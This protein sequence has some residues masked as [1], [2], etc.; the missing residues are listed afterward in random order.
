MYTRRRRNTL[1]S[2]APAKS[3]GPPVRLYGGDVE[4]LTFVLLVRDVMP[5]SGSG[6]VAKIEHLIDAEF[7]GKASGGVVQRVRSRGK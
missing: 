6:N 5:A 7:D 3:A 4:P 2:I 1:K